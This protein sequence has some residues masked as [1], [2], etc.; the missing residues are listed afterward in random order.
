MST[1]VHLQ[2]PPF[3][4]GVYSLSEAAR[5]VKKPSAWVRRAVQGY[6][7][8]GRKGQRGSSPPL[9]R[10]QYAP[11]GGIINLS[12]LD[13]IELVFVRDFLEHG[14]SWPVIRRAAEVAAEWF[15]ETEHPFCVK[16]FATDGS[17][18]FA[19][20]ERQEGKGEQML[21]VPQR[22]HVFA[23]ITTPF[24][25]QLEYSAAGDLLRWFPMGMD[26]PVVLDPRLSF[27][28]PIVAGYGVPTAT[29][30]AALQAGESEDSIAE[31][32][33][34]PQDVVHAALDYERS[35]AA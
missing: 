13:L 32:Y 31:W 4:L 25:K 3:N 11:V 22:Q 9:F 15:R 35:L 23:E 2:R 26:R 21:D 18:I 10:G 17:S 7:F 34:L 6:E 33:E 16:R 29:L 27:G 30:Y 14:V 20:A 19:I 12:F 24:I 28:A 1:E 5:L 8:S